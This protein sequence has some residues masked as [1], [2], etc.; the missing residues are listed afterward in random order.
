[1]AIFNR[2]LNYLRDKLFVVNH[3]YQPIRSSTPTTEQDNA[4]SKDSFPD[5]QNKLAYGIFLIQGLAMLLPW[6]AFITSSEF[7][8]SKFSGSQYANNFQNYFSIG[9]TFLNLIFFGKAL[10]TQRKVDLFR[11]IACSLIVNVLVFSLMALSTLYVELFSSS[12]YF[13]FIMIMLLITG[14]TTSLI[15]N[16]ILALASQF[17]PIHMQAVMR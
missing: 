12:G 3:P 7:F 8:R 11:R 10:Y 14:A 1:M 9:F 15:Q 17:P 16:G 5:F 13:Y 4:L 6:N 2:L